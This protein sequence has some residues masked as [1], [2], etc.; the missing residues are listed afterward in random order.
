MKEKYIKQL[1]K[2]LSL[3]NKAKKEVVRDLNEVFL[4]AAEHGETE[5]QV[6]QR[7]GTPKEFADSIAEQFGVDNTA[8]KKKMGIISIFI[9]VVIS[10]LSFSI[11]TIARLE[12]PPE[13]AIGQ[14]EA[15]TTIQIEGSGSFNASQI[16]L[17][18][19]FAATIITVFLIVRFIRKY[20]R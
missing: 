9:A 2:E 5:R 4:S 7:L 17:M 19:G 14:A 11:H 16:I 13:V 6:I 18:I 1:K 12:T 10:V 20:R 15:M 8:S 3:P